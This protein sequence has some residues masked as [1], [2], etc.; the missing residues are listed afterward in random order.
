M[1]CAKISHTTV[2]PCHKWAKYVKLIVSFYMVEMFKCFC[3][4]ELKINTLPI[5][6][7]SF[8]YKSVLRN[9]IKM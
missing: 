5:Q 6:I 2:A 4:Q 3:S 7:L 9:K 1:M 8:K